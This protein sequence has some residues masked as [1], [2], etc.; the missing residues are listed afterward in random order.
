MT[1]LL[2]VKIIKL[3]IKFLSLP[4]KMHPRLSELK[5]LMMKVGN[6]MK[7]S[8]L[9]YTKQKEMALPLKELIHHAKLPL[10]MMISLVAS[11]LN[12]LKEM[13]S[14]LLTLEKLKLSLFVKMVVMVSLLLN[15]KLSKS[16]NLNKL[17]P[18]VSTM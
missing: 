3:M 17:Q 5:S 7:I 11:D 15:M 6:L 12:R 2:L 10:L 8:S 4:R 16:M 9:I 14:L 1:L 13:Y 18:L